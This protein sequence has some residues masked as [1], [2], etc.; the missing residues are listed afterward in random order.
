MENWLSFVETISAYVFREE[1]FEAPNKTKDDGAKKKK[2]RQGEK[3]TRWGLF[4]S[5]SLVCISYRD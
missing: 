4:S 1:V 2:R 5:L 3:K